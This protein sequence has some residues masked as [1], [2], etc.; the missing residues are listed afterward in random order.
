MS[1]K[2][3]EVELSESSAASSDDLLDSPKEKRRFMYDGDKKK[4]PNSLPTESVNRIF[5]AS[6]TSFRYL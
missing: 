6:K 2:S 5:G 1:R 3:V 4:V